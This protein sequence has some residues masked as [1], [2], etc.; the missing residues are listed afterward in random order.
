MLMVVMSF[1]RACYGRTCVVYIYINTTSSLSI[2][3]V[4]HNLLLSNTD[5]RSLYRIKINYFE[6]T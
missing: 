3:F 4:S 2:R 6:N 1:M 5:C